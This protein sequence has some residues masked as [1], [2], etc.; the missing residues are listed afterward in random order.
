MT[1]DRERIASLEANQANT[2]KTVD[3]IFEYMKNG[4]EQRER[5]IVQ[6][7]II[8]G[9]QVDMKKY[10]DR[11]DAERTAHDKRITEVEGFQKR[12]IRIAVLAGS[13][14]SFLALGGSKVIEKVLGV[15]S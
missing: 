9:N 5:M 15:F 8:E 3:A 7:A 1:G 10:Q 12:Q 11:C 13:F 14:G 6:L 2:T 4:K